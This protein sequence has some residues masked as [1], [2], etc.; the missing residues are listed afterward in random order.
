[1]AQLDVQVMQVP[2]GGSPTLRTDTKREPTTWPET[3]GCGGV[4]SRRAV[5]QELRADPEGGSKMWT[6][7]SEF[8]WNQQA[9]LMSN[10][11][12]GRQGRTI[13]VTPGFLTQNPG[14]I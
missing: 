8:M 4:C 12:C 3:W 10:L 13:G 1:M 11:R 5:S 7:V 2:K 14:M 6:Q 9:L